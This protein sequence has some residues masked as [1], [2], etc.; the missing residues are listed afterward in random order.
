M[1]FLTKSGVGVWVSFFNQSKLYL[2][3]MESKK[4]LQ[5]VDFTTAINNFISGT[6]L[7]IAP[8]ERAGLH[9]TVSNKSDCRSTSC[10]FESQ[11]GHITFTEI[12]HKI[13]S[14][15]IRPLPLIQEGQLSVTRESMCASTGP[16]CSKPR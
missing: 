1:Q 8:D 9:S 15:V 6:F 11:L 7:Y 10:K 13:I 2:Y 14:K 16:S 5:E 4:F 3:H 12:N